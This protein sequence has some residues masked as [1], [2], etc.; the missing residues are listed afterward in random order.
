[1]Y[2]VFIFA[3]TT[4]GRQLT[5]FLSSFGVMVYAFTATEYGESLIGKRDH[6][7][8]SHQKL[9]GEEMEERIRRE[10]PNLVLDATHPYADLVTE[11]IRLACEN[12]HTDLVRLI[13]DSFDCDG[14]DV[15]Y[16]E[17]TEQAVKFL[18]NTE[19]NIFL[20]TG[21]KELMKYTAV[22]DYEK[23]MFVR[24]LSLPDVVKY[25]ANLGFHGSHLICMQGPFSKELNTAM[26]RQYNCSWM[27]TKESG[28]E[29]GFLEKLEAA[30][31]AGSKLLVIGRPKQ[32]QGVTYKECRKMLQKRFAIPYSPDITLVGVGTGSV[33]TMTAEA[34]RACQR[35]ELLIGAGRPLETV[36]KAA[37][38]RKKADR[39]Q[40]YRGEYIVSYIKEH[41][42]YDHIVIA[43]SGDPGFYSGAKT[44]YKVL[45][46]ETE[47][48]LKT[49]C[50][51][52]SLAYF[53]SRLHLSW[54][55]VVFASLHGQKSSLVSRIAANKKVFAI[56][57][58][59]TQV[60]QLAEELLEYGLDDVTIHVGERLS[61]PEEKIRSGF[62][63]DFLFCK[64][65]VLS[66]LCV[67]NP[68]PETLLAVHGLKDDRFIRGKVPMTKEEIRSISLSK[69]RL[70]K[71]AVCYDI[72]AGTGSVSMEMAVRACEGRV[73]AVEKKPEAAELIYKNRRKFRADNI[74]V[75]EGSAPEILDGLESP[76]HVFIGGSS[77]NLTKILELILKKNP[78]VRMVI[79]CITLE[80]L[81]EAVMALKHL[82]VTEPD[83]VNVS[84]GKAKRA[85]N[86]HL[87]LGENPVFIISCEGTSEVRH[88]D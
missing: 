32:E 72:G 35:A 22:P 40:E 77:G 80:T 79:N 42:F 3:G 10:K 17:S 45:G 78:K 71:D 63:S 85:G 60:R 25:C 1:M 86:Y 56:L 67:E 66:V 59:G 6:V 19:G 39:Y 76:T 58:N 52:S 38:E 29:G 73:Y 5:E 30:R 46:N 54:E 75:I 55:D 26:L 20:T 84:V 65:D 4:E 83:V 16:V 61:Y 47:W 33:E 18:S 8:L 70:T 24:V 11:N 62:P 27:V 87:M 88:E 81:S 7:V 43:L 44:L 82:P 31:K 57:G 41:P 2:K 21:S 50:G 13:R 64:T 23:R 74:T 37:G 49:V 36:I 14:E 15:T 69:L 28:R 34:I 53:M 68:H 12:T 9:S 48:K 51:I